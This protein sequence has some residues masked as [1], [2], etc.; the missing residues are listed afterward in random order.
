MLDGVRAQIH[1]NL[2]NTVRKCKTKHKIKRCNLCG[3]CLH[4]SFSRHEDKSF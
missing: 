1:L 2:A 3:N 4:C